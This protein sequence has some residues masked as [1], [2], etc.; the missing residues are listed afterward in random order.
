MRGKLAI[1]LST[2]L[3]ILLP[4]VGAFGLGYV[5]FESA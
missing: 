3:L 5:A 1:C 2:T 4:A